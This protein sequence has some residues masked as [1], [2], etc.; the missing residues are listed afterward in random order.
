MSTPTPPLKSPPRTTT[1]PR[2]AIAAGATEGRSAPKNAAE[3]V[4]SA[5]RPNPRPSTERRP[6][7]WLSIYAPGRATPTA[8]SWCA[9]GRD[10]FAA[11]HKRAAALI[12]DHAAHRALCPLRN[13]QEGR[14]AA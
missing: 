3:G 5:L 2:P 10:R 1:D 6:V 13:C 9:C 8:R 14:A 7:A 12:A 11:G 4:L